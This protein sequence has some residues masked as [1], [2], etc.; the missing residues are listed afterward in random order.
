MVVESAVPKF[1]QR[2][3]VRKSWARPSLVP[4]RRAKVVFL[5]GQ[6]VGGEFREAIEAESARHGDIVQERFVDSYYNLTVKSLMVLKW[7]TQNCHG[8]SYVLKADDDVFV[9]VKNLIDIVHRVAI[10]ST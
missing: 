9:N 8:F 6:T 4:A 7:A 10:Q 2:D 5:V 1:A 3:V